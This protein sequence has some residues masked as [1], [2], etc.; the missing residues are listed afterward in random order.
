MIKIWAEKELLNLKRI[1]QSSMN[2][3]EP[4]SLKANVLV[5]G[6]IDKDNQPAPR[7]KNAGGL[8]A[9][10]YSKTNL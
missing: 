5:M 6:F 9:E 3:P 4:L 8:D 2:R 7:L 10:Q 1:H